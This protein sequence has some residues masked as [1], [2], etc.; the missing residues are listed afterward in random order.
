MGTR[1]EVTTVLSLALAA[2]CPGQSSQCPRMVPSEVRM[3]LP[4]SHPPGPYPYVRTTAQ[5]WVFCDGAPTGGVPIQAVPSDS[6]MAAFVSE[7]ARSAFDTT[8]QWPNLILTATS[9]AVAPPAGTYRV[10]VAIS[11][12]DGRAASLPVSLTFTAEPFARVSGTALLFTSVPWSMNDQDLTVWFPNATTALPFT[13]AAESA[14]WLSVTPASGAGYTKLTVHVDPTRVTPGDYIGF[15][16]ITAAGAANSPVRVY[17][18]LVL[19]PPALSVGPPSLTFS[20]VEGGPPPKSQ[21]LSVTDNRAPLN[22]TVSSDSMWLT[23]SPVTGTTQATVNVSVDGAGLSQG[24][25][26]G[27]LTFT[28]PGATP[29]TVAVTLTVTPSATITLSPR[30]FSRAYWPGIETSILPGTILERGEIAV[31]S[32]TGR[33]PSPTEAAGCR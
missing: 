13:V 7:M 6:R 27:N 5:V 20:Q 22:F 21:S 31:T 19:T 23:A 16:D 17:V 8:Y 1:I 12:A 15:L 3:F 30:Q 9:S 26:K 32:E 4:V 29:A 14:G 25:Y 10:P 2:I 28:A 18:R 33:A 24:T 11:T